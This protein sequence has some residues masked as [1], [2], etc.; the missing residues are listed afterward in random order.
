MEDRSGWVP[1]GHSKTHYNS[2]AERDAA[3]DAMNA[4]FQLAGVRRRWSAT[5]RWLEHPYALMLCE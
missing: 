3:R 4:D 2:A 1:T 5:D